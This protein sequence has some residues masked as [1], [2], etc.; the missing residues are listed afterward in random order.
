MGK[1]AKVVKNPCKIVTNDDEYCEFVKYLKSLSKNES[2]DDLVRHKAIINSNQDVIGITMKN[3]RD[4]AKQISKSCQFEFLKVAEN[5]IPLDV[6]FEETLI[7]GLVIVEI[8][9]LKVQFKLLQK[10][11]NKINNWA[12]CDSVV[13]SLKILKKSKEKNL[14]FEKYINLCQSEKEFV[15]RFGIVTLMSVYLDE[16]HIDRIYE[17]IKSINKDEYYIKMAQAWLIAS[18]FIVNREKTYN[19]LKRKCLNKFVQNKSISKCRDSIQVSKDDK[20]R[21]KQLRM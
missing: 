14:Y 13:T 18:G 1:F 8:Q 15:V 17:V 7:E 10:W 5:K 12:T 4:V 19:L 20:E 2:V 16:E 6:Y 21:L 3:I 11:M 9:D